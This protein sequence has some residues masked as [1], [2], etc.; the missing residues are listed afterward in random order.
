MSELNRANIIL[1]L[2]SVDFNA[3]DFIWDNELALVMKRREEGTAYVIPII[4]RK[5]TGGSLPY[6]KLQAL[7]RNATAVTEYPNRDDA[8][9]EIAKGKDISEGIETHL[10]PIIRNSPIPI[11]VNSDFNIP[12]GA[13]REKHK[14]F[15]NSPDAA[16]MAVASDSYDSINELA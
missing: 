1:L 14:Q 2:I 3:S 11:E 7:P 10:S 4:L 6:A 12:S 13:D 9:T 15:W 8:F 5:C 16:V